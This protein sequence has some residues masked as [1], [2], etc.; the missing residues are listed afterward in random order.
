MHMISPEHAQVSVINPL[1]RPDSKR[2]TE[3][4]LLKDQERALCSAHLPFL[5][6]LQWADGGAFNILTGAPSSY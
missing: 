3:V 1:C 5:V 2:W 4:G 6:G